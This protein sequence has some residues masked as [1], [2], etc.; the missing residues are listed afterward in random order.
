MDPNLQTTLFYTLSTVA[1]TLE[2]Q[3]AALQ[4]AGASEIF[5]DTMSGACDD[6]P[7]IAIFIPETNN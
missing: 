7:A 4:T 6:R 2:Q 3:N 1:Q 5:A